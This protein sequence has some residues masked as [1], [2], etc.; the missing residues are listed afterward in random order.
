MDHI[1]STPV[2]FKTHR[3]VTLPS[4]C[5]RDFLLNLHAFFF[6]YLLR[7]TNP[8]HYLL[9]HYIPVIDKNTVSMFLFALFSYSP[10]F[11]DF[12]SSSTID[13]STCVQVVR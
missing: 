7:F 11:Y 13:L 3:D 1:Q 10:P 4:L 6:C 5:P 9:V 12:V 2:T 8:Y